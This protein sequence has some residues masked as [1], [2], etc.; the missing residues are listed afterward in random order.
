MFNPKA[1]IG[2]IITLQLILLGLIIFTAIA[3]ST[4]ET[5]SKEEYTIALTGHHVIQLLY[6][7]CVVA[8][9]LFLNSIYKKWSNL[10]EIQE[11]ARLHGK[12]EMFHDIERY[13]AENPDNE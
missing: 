4:E 10:E 9:Q 12:R 13:I 1:S 3:A 2:L 8:L 6:L 7:A 11:E 5:L